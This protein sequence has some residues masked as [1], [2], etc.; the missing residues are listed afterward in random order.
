MPHYCLITIG[1]KALIGEGVLVIKDGPDFVIVV[2][3][4]A[5]IKPYKNFMK[6]K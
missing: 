4:P 6:S 5:V 2:G 1:K 3:N